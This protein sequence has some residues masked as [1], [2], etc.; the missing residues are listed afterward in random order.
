MIDVAARW[1]RIAA[2]M[3]LLSAFVAALGVY[4]FKTY[5]N[6]VEER[7]KAP[8]FRI[9]HFKDWKDYPDEFTKFFED[10]VAWMHLQVRRYARFKLDTWGVSPTPRVWVGEGGWLFYNHEA[11]STYIPATDHRLVARR[12]EW[13]QALYEWRV[14]LAERGMRLQVVVAP[15]KQSIYSEYLPAVERKRIGLTPLDVLL[16]ELRDRDP[17]VAVLDLR[18]PLQEGRTNQRLY[19]KSDT[20]WN[21]YGI[22]VGYRSTAHALGIEPL[23]NNAVR[24]GTGATKH[25]DLPLKLGYWPLE[26]EPFDHIEITSP[27]A[28]KIELTMDARDEASLDYLNSRLYVQDNEKLPKVVL[29]HDSFGDGIFSELLAEHFGRLLCVP[30]NHMDPDVIIREK[31]DI[32]ILEIVE[33]LFQGIGARR[34]T[35]PPRRSLTR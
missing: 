18:R 5:L 7:A 21:P 11:D 28:R 3:T 27:R 17:A 1:S 25:G 13:T 2:Q 16:K 31:P 22:L 14:W 29:F 9:G 34:P 12:N 6:V 35:D 26:D 15:D 32:V 8:K 30:S 33:R 24:T 4:C 10:R 20:H 23:S 19:F